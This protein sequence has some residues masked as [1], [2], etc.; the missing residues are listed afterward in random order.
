MAKCEGRTLLSRQYLCTTTLIVVQVCKFVEIQST[1]TAE[2][3]LVHTWSLGWSW[4]MQHNLSAVCRCKKKKKKRQRRSKET[5]GCAGKKEGR[6][7]V[8]LE[9]E[10][11]YSRGTRSPGGGGTGCLK[12]SY[13]KANSSKFPPMLS[14]SHFFFLILLSPP[15]QLSFL[16]FTRPTPPS[17]TNAERDGRIWLPE[18]WGIWN[19]HSFTMT[20]LDIMKEAW[21]Y[22]N[23]EQEKWLSVNTLFWHNGSCVWRQPP[24]FLCEKWLLTFQE[25]H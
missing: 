23:S 24:G 16:M 14:L 4:R 15:T 11:R 2:E 9:C 19:V 7:P 17:T 8:S 22:E 6:L 25:S 20:V 12:R 5:A 21:W 18:S 10:P 1:I 3:L 13:I